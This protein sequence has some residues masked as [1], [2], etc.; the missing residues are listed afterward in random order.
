MATKRAPRCPYTRLTDYQ[1][2]VLAEVAVRHK[3]PDAHRWPASTGVTRSLVA[4]GMLTADGNV[5]EAGYEALKHCTWFSPG[6]RKTLA[7]LT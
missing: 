3:L 4:R 1:G 2:H 6:V 5:T 7:G